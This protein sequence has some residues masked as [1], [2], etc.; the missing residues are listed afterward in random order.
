MNVKSVLLIEGGLNLLIMLV[1][2]GVGISTQSI[3]LISDAIHSLSDLGNNII[4]LI[5]SHVSM[6]EADDNHHFGHG[7]AEQLAIFTLAVLLVV[8]AIEIVINA[9]R[10]Y[11]SFVT[12]SHL[13]LALMVAVLCINIGLTAWQHFWAKR[14]KSGLLEAEAKHTLSDVF[15]TVAAIVGWQFGVYGLPWVDTLVAIIV[16]GLVI[17][18]GFTL[19]KKSTVFLMDS[20][21]LSPRQIRDAVMQLTEVVGVHKVR[22]REHHD[23]KFA[24]LTILVNPHYTTVQAHQ[25]S[26]HVEQL[27][28]E[29]FGIDDVVVHIEPAH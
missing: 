3:A 15:T 22:A 24:D 28:L 19:L 10:H 4:A 14:L 9:V 17:Y 12:Q 2:L 26:E 23:K 11:G 1:K 18:L 29:R 21:T 8:V 20:S 6:Q 25:V 13:G 16:A 5:A 7:K 27:L